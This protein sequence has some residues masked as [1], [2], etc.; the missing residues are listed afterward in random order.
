M[1]LAAEGSGGTAAAPAP[2]YY[3]LTGQSG[4][5]LYMAPEVFLNL[6]YNEKADI[7]SLGVVIFELFY[8]VQLSDM[9]LEER[10]WAQAKKFAKGVAQGERVST[11]VLPPAIGQIVA[12]CWE[13]V[14]SACLSV[15]ME[16]THAVPEGRGRVCS[17]GRCVSELQNP[18]LR[19]AAEDV[20]AS[21]EALEDEPE[22]HLSGE[23]VPVSMHRPSLQ[24]ASRSWVRRSFSRMASAIG[25]RLTL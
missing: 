16:T 20:L 2:P 4:S 21:L 3:Y 5:L 8:G 25:R 23:T 11:A 7:F 18:A 13:Q 10:T 14:C 12:A 6:P 1:W 19:P 22:F 9:V 17:R 15:P 24:G